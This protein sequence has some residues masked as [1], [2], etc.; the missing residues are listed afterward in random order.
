MNR[1]FLGLA[2]LG[3]GLLLSG[4]ARCSETPK[5]KPQTLEAQLD[6]DSAGSQAEEL[7][8]HFRGHYG[9]RHYGYRHN[10]W[11]RPYYGGHGWHGHRYYTPYYHYH[12]RTHYHYG[13]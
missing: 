13:Y 1:F 2:L 6:D 8:R 4:E 12:Y 5:A 10:H 7:G 9:Y 3:A 11:Y